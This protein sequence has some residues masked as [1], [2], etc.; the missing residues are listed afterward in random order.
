MAVT[1]N[2]Y[3]LNQVKEEIFLSLKRGFTSKNSAIRIQKGKIEQLEFHLKTSELK[4]SNLVQQINFCLEEYG[5]PYQD[6]ATLKT[7]IQNC[8]QSSKTGSNPSPP[9]PVMHQLH[10]ES[11]LAITASKN[12]ARLTP[13]TEELTNITPMKTADFKILESYVKSGNEPSLKMPQI[14]LDRCD[15]YL[16][17]VTKDEKRNKITGKEV[18]EVFQDTRRKTT[19]VITGPVIDLEVE[20]LHSKSL[21][22]LK[23]EP[24]R[25]PELVAKTPFGPQLVLKSDSVNNNS[26][27]SSTKR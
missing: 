27:T 23:L 1:N 8:I 17:S 11:S 26:E 3:I 18:T 16:F 12:K 14:I 21:S 4:F 7:A 15:D 22:K 9:N 10:D 5:K 19:K 6:A 2:D 24:K 20:V 13:N 25:Q